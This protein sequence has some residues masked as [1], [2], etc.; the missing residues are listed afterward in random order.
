ML[1]LRVPALLLVTAL[2]LLF[3]SQAPALVTHLNQ[4]S[5]R[6]ERRL[7]QWDWQD[8]AE[9]KLCRAADGATPKHSKD[10]IPNVIHFILLARHGAQVDLTYAQYLAV[11]AAIVR[12]R[13][14]EVKIHTNGMDTGN[15]WWQ[16]LAPKVT[17]ERVDATQILDHRGLPITNMDLPHQTDILRIAIL[18]R[19]GGIY[20]D[21]DVYAFKPFTDLLNSHRDSLMGHEGGNRYGLCNAVV[22]SRPGS[23][24]LVK[25]Q[26][27]YETF[28]PKR[29]NEH[30]VLMPKKLQ[31]M[32]PHLICPLSP[33][34]FFWP[35]WGKNHIRYMHEPIGPADTSSLLKNMTAFDGAMYKNQLALHAW[36]TSSKEYLR[37]LSPEYIKNTDTRFNILLRDVASAAL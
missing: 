16:E 32:H 24:F 13:A 33:S 19:E 31:V 29:W 30:S 18:L 5:W 27:T 28:S 22:V 11:K 14:R 26:K 15:Q 4:L 34:V 8:T 10:A 21:T 37:R 1:R 6:V 36:S 12:M 25:W 17:L 2:L 35:T 20:M 7:V 3:Y 9:E 23:E